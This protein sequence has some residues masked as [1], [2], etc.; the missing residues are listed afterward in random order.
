MSNE[1]R[2]DRLEEIRKHFLNADQHAAFLSSAPYRDLLK[3]AKQYEDEL[4]QILSW[5]L[6]EKI[7]LGAQE[8][9]SIRRVLRVEQASVEP[10][11]PVEKPLTPKQQ[12]RQIYPN[13]YA[14]TA[15]NRWWI[16]SS[17]KAGERNFIINKDEL[18]NSTP[19]FAWQMAASKLKGKK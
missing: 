5:A 8:V 1:S 16:A 7:A 18:G 9:E 11:K 19:N 13:S 12:V 4:R 17:H 6:V 14:Y 10:A 2:I 3:I 15:N